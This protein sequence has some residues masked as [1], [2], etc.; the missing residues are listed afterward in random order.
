M[1]NVPSGQ[2]T[3]MDSII[4]SL[5]SPMWVST[6]DE[7]QCEG[8][9]NIGRMYSLVAVLRVTIAP[10]PCGASESRA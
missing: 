8:F 7:P 9:A 5:A 1:L 4:D 3:W 2:A 10:M 6:D